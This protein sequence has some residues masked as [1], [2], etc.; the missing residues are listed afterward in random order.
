MQKK[1]TSELGKS[2]KPDVKSDEPY[3]NSDKPNEDQDTSS[4]VFHKTYY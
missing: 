4:E 2:E 3:G 1:N